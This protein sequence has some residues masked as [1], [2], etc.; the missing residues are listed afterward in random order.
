ME[1]GWITPVVSILACGA[2]AAWDEKN[3][4]KVSKFLY[5]KVLN[6]IY[7]GTLKSQLKCMEKESKLEKKIN[8]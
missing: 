2:A 6:R 3:H 1:Y 7:S 4:E 8:Q 5:W